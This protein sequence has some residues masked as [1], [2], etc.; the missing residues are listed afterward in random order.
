MCAAHLFGT[1]ARAREYGPWRDT[2]IWENKDGKRICTVI[3]NRVSGCQPI[4][5]RVQ[6][7]MNKKKMSKKLISTKA[8]AAVVQ[9]ERRRDNTKIV[10]VL[11]IALP[12]PM[13]EPCLELM[14]DKPIVTVSTG[15]ESSQCTFIISYSVCSLLRST[16]HLLLFIDF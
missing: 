9:P 7:E 14:V 6:K 16:I 4:N 12:S 10:V 5:P 1:R 8:A 15:I 2:L 13:V 3:A 11:F